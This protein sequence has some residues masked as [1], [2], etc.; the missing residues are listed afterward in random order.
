MSNSSSRDTVVFQPDVHRTM[1]RGVNKLVRAIRPTLG[2]IVRIVAIDRILDD[3]M[4]EMLDN[5]AIIAQRIIQLPDRNEDAG[6]MLVREVVTRV[7]E[8]VGDGTASAAVIFQ[9]VLDGGIRYLAAGGDSVLLRKHLELGTELVIDGLSKSAIPISGGKDLTHLAETLCHDPSMA[10][11]IG[12]IFATIGEHGRLE[13]RAG[14]TRGMSREYVEGM[15]WEQGVVSRLMLADAEKIEFT[16]AS[17]LIS[18]LDIKDPKQL[19]PVLQLALSNGIRELLLVV[20]SISDGA[21]A[22]LAA[23]NDPE[24]LTTAAVKAPGWGKEEQAES[25]QDLAIVTGGRPF[26]ETAGETFAPITTED[27]GRA[28][29]VWADR[30]NFGIVGGRGDSRRLREHM[31][32]LQDAYENADNLVRRDKLQARFGKLLG[33]SA[34]LWIGG[35]TELQ[36]EEKIETAKRTA[37][38]MR[39]AMMQG[40]VPGGGVALLAC[41]PALT[42][43]VANADNPDERAAYRILSQAIT[44]P[45]GAIVANAGFDVAEA[46]AQLDQHPEGFGFD[47]RT[48]DTVD[49]VAAGIVDAAAVQKAAVYGAITSA[50]LALSVEVLVY[51]PNQEAVTAKPATPAKRKLL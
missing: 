41:L 16:D 38:A 31:A 49:M 4:P 1:A 34:T 45:F 8:Q 51:R 18:D 30:R 17:I 15:Y 48:G 5:G 22:F 11:L 32:D 13:I 14:R 50:A 33:G 26:V 19:M 37:S 43:M 27:L 39:G 21:I 20:G 42:K 2:P 35:D 29:R 10:E 40:V 25:L 46:M 12:E 24:R 47:V 28:R 23:N 36:V 44:Q 6:A 9:Q 7:G 3:R